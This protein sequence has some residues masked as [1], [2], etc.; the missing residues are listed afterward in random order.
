MFND[1]SRC[2]AC[3]KVLGFWEL[4]PVLSFLLQKGRCRRCRSRISWQY[5]LVELL[6]GALFLF[7][8]LKWQS[9]FGRIRELG[10]LLWWFLAAF[11]AAVLAV[12]DFKHK[13]LPGKFSWAFLILS[14]LGSFVFRDISAVE[15]G[16]ALAPAVFLAV[17]SLISGGRWLG[18]G[19]VKLMFGIGLFLSWPQS[20]LALLFAFWLGALWGLGLLWFQRGV[21]IKSELPFGPFLI[22]GMYLAF[23][24]P[25][26]FRALFLPWL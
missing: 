16:L 23:F 17:L 25:E 8:F 1:R 6:L 5:P 19:D 11:L 13:I 24:F 2:F 7:S 4:W 21:T 3:G 22:L 12:Y 14:F 15:L 18:W 26:F 10:I 20:L 9:E